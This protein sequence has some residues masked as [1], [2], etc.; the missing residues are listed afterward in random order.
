MK[1]VLLSLLVIVVF[2]GVTT[3]PAKT[4]VRAYYSG[5]SIVYKDTVVVGSANT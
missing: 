3:L 1:K 5:D 2:V 4:K